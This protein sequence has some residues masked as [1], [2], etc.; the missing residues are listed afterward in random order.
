M[1]IKSKDIYENNLKSIFSH[2]SVIS[3]NTL[4]RTNNP[5]NLYSMKQNKIDKSQSNSNLSSTKIAQSQLFQFTFSQILRPLTN[6]LYLKKDIE[7]NYENE[8]IKLNSAIP[9]LSRSFERNSLS[10]D[11][12]Q[13]EEFSDK[14]L[15]LEDIN[16]S[17]NEQIK[18]LNHSY[19]ENSNQFQRAEEIKTQIFKNN[20]EDVKFSNF[21]EIFQK[22]NKA[23]FTERENNKK[24]FQRNQLNC[25]K[26]NKNEN[27]INKY[28]LISS[29]KIQKENTKDTIDFKI[30]KIQLKDPRNITNGNP[31]ELETF[32]D[33]INKKIIKANAISRDKYIRKESERNLMRKKLKEL[34]FNIDL[35]E[36]NLKSQEFELA[37]ISETQKLIL[38]KLN[39]IEKII[40]KK[41][42]GI[43]EQ[44]ISSFNNI[45]DLL[46]KF[47]KG[48]NKCSEIEYK[49]KK[50][51]LKKMKMIKTLGQEK[52]DLYKLLK[53]SEILNKIESN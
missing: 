21:S 15:E 41:T 3:N 24:I 2:D 25:Q 28:Y 17:I 9:V 22:Q 34:S 14:S 19:M 4:Q 53:I 40:D 48:L 5:F 27:F 16:K 33:K 7:K 50:L 20:I 52:T 8:E 42:M 6:S 36:N 30:E 38:E 44:S 18:I 29:I 45:S 12:N 51:L 31:E 47:D 10:I 46:I 35:E 13:I 37:S 26:S 11:N 39:S 32:I 49:A 43:D 1:L 23:K